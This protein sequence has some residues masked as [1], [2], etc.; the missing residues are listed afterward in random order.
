[1][2]RNSAYSTSALGA[3][4]RHRHL[5]CVAARRSDCDGGR[6]IAAVEHIDGGL[7]EIQ[8]RLDVPLPPVEGET[9]SQLTLDAA[10]NVGY[11]TT[12]SVFV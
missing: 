1:V 5:Q 4:E 2:W 7:I 6:M 10:V 8:R 3:R 9:L 12:G 11:A